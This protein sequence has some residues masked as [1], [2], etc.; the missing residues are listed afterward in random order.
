MM[1]SGLY[2]ESK[3]SRRVDEALS[4]GDGLE[5]EDLERCAACFTGCFHLETELKGCLRA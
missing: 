4:V 2:I 3:R 5:I 1:P